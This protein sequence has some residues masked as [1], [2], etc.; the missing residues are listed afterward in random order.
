M[1]QKTLPVIECF[2]AMRKTRLGTNAQP[3]GTK[4]RP[5]IT[6][7]KLTTLWISK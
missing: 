6:K 3:H 1:D 4:Y 2:G 7:L 5:L